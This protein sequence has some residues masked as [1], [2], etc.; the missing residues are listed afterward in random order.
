MTEYRPLRIALL[1]AGSVGA[2]VA[3]LLTENKN[4]L[5]DRLREIGI[6]EPTIHRVVRAQIMHDQAVMTQ[7]CAPASQVTCSTLHR[8]SVCSR[9][10]YLSMT[11]LVYSSSPACSANICVHW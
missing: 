1:G 7:R 2:Q 11:K 10:R 5:A 3:R 8:V 9:S 4:E 6:D